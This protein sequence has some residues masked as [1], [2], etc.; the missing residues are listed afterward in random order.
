M[1]ASDS[2]G[3]E[4]EEL[5]LMEAF[6]ERIELN[7]YLPALRELG[8]ERFSDFEEIEDQDLEDMGMSTLKKR[9]LRRAL[10]E[11]AE[12]FGN[13]TLSCLNSKN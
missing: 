3:A 1:V 11:E 12:G 9:R 2:L 5:C 10:Q 13:S 7:K 6:L 8:L 4:A